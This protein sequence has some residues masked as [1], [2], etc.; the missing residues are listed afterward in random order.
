MRR[1][2]FTLKLMND[3]LSKFIPRDIVALVVIAGGLWLKF[4]GADGLVGT[5]LTAIVFYYFGK[6]V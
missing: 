6:R 3:L 4:S 2:E 5:L 1:I